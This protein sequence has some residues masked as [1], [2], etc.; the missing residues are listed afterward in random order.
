MT[1]D[2]ADFISVACA[3]QS[4]RRTRTFSIYRDESDKYAKYSW[5]VPESCD[6]DDISQTNERR[7]DPLLPNPMAA[8]HPL[9]MILPPETLRRQTIELPQ[10]ALAKNPERRNGRIRRFAGTK[11]TITR[12]NPGGLRSAFSSPFRWI[13]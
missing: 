13:L 11:M 5:G 1:S 6:P 3:V 12:S 9:V 4:K 8:V 10:E 7:V 2:I